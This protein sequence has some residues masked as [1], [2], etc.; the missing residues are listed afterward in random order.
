M[1]ASSG[2]KKFRELDRFKVGFYPFRGPDAPFALLS[3]YYAATI[4]RSWSESVEERHS[5][6]GW[7]ITKY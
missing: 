2:R 6:E 4:D 3:A 1:S 7:R 5:G